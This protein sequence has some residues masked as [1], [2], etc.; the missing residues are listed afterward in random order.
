[1]NRINQRESTNAKYAARRKPDCPDPGVGR[2]K[3][4]SEGYF[5]SPWLKTESNYPGGSQGKHGDDAVA[6]GGDY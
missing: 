1:M 4:T 2:R 6:T 5:Q 3:L